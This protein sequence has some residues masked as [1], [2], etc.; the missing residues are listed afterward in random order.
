MAAINWAEQLGK[1]NTS[2]DEVYILDIQTGR[3]TPSNAGIGTY[4]T[5][6]RKS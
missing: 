4:Q 1:H 5:F 2:A 3:K 6:Y